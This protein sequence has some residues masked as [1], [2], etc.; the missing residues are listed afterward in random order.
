ML[1]G[2]YSR[3]LYLVYFQ[4]FDFYSIIAEVQPYAHEIQTTHGNTIIYQA[5]FIIA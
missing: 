5:F 4:I 2:S 1:V 3:A